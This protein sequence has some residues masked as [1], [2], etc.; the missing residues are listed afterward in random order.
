MWWNIVEK[1]YIECRA[2]TIVTNGLTVC[3][4]TGRT[5][6]SLKTVEKGEGASVQACMSGKS[7]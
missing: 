2:D 1:I 3:G 5:V 4:L 7:I 6:C